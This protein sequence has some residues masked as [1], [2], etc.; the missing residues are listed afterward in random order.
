MREFQ[1]CKLAEFTGNHKYTSKTLRDIL[2]D[3]RPSSVSLLGRK[4]GAWR[5]GYAVSSSSSLARSFSSYLSAR[6]ENKK[7]RASDAEKSAAC[8]DRV[9]GEGREKR[10]RD[11]GRAHKTR[12]C[13]ADVINGNCAKVARR[14]RV[15]PVPH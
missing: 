14:T 11:R 6:N 15:T 8:D 3:S 9:K 2:N 10:G 5:A 1:A 13:E 7:T 12:W 4:V